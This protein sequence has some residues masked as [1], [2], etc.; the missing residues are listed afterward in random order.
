MSEFA[1]SEIV[2]RLEERSIVARSSP[3]AAMLAGLRIGLV[4]G[5]YSSLIVA[6]A[7][8]STTGLDRAN[9][10]LSASSFAV[11]VTVA[12]TLLLRSKSVGWEYVFDA[13]GV[14]CSRYGAPLWSVPWDA[15]RLE[16]YGLLGSRARI[17]LPDG[18]RIRFGEHFFELEDMKAVRSVFAAFAIEKTK[19]ATSWIRTGVVAAIGGVGG[20]WAIEASRGPLFDA[21][22][23][24]QGWPI[25]P[26]VVLLLGGIG[27]ATMML[28]MLLALA[29]LETASRRWKG[30][31]HG[32]LWID[33][34]RSHL[35][36]VPAV[37]MEP[38]KKYKYLDPERLKGHIGVGW[39]VVFCGALLFL[40]AL[41]PSED[42]GD[43]AIWIIRAF[44]LGLMV[45]PIG[46]IRRD[47]ELARSLG[48]VYWVEGGRLHVSDAAR[49]ET[50]SSVPGRTARGEPEARVAKFM[51]WWEEYENERGRIQIDRRFLWPVA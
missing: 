43:A 20:F 6:A 19:R 27:V 39:G 47:H 5:V 45:A 26:T 14:T 35:R 23:A 13:H 8:V 33:Y 7:L 49:T 16:G 1:R 11:L 2:R 36:T 32:P 17:I 40:V 31:K 24:G 28:V 50:F 12:L 42:A 41:F 18:R 4:L 25:W 51:V 48:Y 46:S 38:G 22:D 29:R 10:L 34:V 44:A 30:S 21:I 9:S 3:R 15:F 37:E